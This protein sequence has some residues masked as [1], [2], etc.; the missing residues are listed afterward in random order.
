MAVLLLLGSALAG[1]CLAFLFRAVLV[2]LERLTRASRLAGAARE[3]DGALI[4]VRQTLEA[5]KAEPTPLTPSQEDLLESVRQET[6][7]LGQVAQ[8]LL[9]LSRGEAGRAATPAQIGCARAI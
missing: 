7:R 5:L 4:P 9:A 8:N 2:P 3:I 6:D 1:V